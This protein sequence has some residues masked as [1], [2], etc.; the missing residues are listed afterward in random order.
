MLKIDVYQCQHKLLVVHNLCLMTFVYNY[1][2]FDSSG[3]EKNSHGVSS[4]SIHF[5]VSAKIKCDI[6]T[7]T[8][9]LA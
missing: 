7:E 3:K 9:Q 2:M 4:F 6:M 5:P 8:T 1:V